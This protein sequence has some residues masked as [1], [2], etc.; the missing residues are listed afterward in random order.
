MLLRHSW[1]ASHLTMRL[2]TAHAE[3][4]SLRTS[5]SWHRSQQLLWAINCCIAFHSAVMTHGTCLTMFQ[6][7]PCVQEL[8][9]NRLSFT[10]DVVAAFQPSHDEVANRSCPAACV[11]ALMAPAACV[12]AFHTLQLT[13][14]MHFFTKCVKC[15]KFTQNSDFLLVFNKFGKNPAKFLCG[16]HFFR[17]NA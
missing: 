4:C 16:T 14:G 12:Q 6:D 5:I 17:K 13:L 8:K 3:S 15:P 2:P 11:Q 7:H 9:M 1:P 10:T